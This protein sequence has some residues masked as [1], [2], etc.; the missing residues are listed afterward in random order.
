MKSQIIMMKNRYPSST[1]DSM[2]IWD[3][4]M[5]NRA[6]LLDR[7]PS[8]TVDNIVSNSF[9]ISLRA[10]LTLNHRDRCMNKQLICK[11]TCT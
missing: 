3:D 5:I 9:A 10:T 1:A 11:K 2:D 8:I 7:L 4:V 6:M